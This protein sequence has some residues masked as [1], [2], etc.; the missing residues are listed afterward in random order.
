M[1]RDMPSLP[2]SGPQPPLRV[3]F[4]TL[5]A[6]FVL[7]LLVA[8]CSSS[9][10]EVAARSALN[11]IADTVDPSYQLAVQGCKDLQ[12]LTMREGE[13]GKRTA[14]STETEINAISA[15]CHKMVDAFDEIRRFHEQGVQYVEDGRFEQ[16][17][18]EVDKAREA[19]RTMRE[20]TDTP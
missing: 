8:C 11:I 4:Y 7:V 15:R 19:W 17:L 12:D 1:K 5:A 20:R 14:V 9:V 10:T 6:S 2:P 16:A 3:P 13:A 18:T